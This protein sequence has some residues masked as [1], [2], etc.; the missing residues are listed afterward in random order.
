[1]LIV[2]LEQQLLQVVA[3]RREFEGHLVGGHSGERKLWTVVFL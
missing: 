3:E 2:T 1:M